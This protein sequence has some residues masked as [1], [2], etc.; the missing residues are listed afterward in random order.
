SLGFAGFNDTLQFGGSLEAGYRA[1][2]VFHVDG[3]NVG[4]GTMADMSVTIAGN[5]E[6]FFA[7][8][9]GYN[10]TIWATQSYEIN[11]ITPQEI[12]VQFSTQVVNDTWLY[13]DGITFSGVSDFSSTLV[14]DHIEVIDA[15]GDLV[16]SGV[17]LSSASGTQY[18]M[19]PEPASMMALSLGAVALL[20][21]RKK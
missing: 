17:T 21:R 20:R 9:Q 11:G 3:F 2:Y 16:T 5:N 6:Q 12:A 4:P 18:N 8:D 19:V 15:N 7:F 14:L 1:R 10:N 13:E